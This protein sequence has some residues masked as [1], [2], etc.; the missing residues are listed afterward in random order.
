M[1]NRIITI[2]R[3]FGSGG[4]TIGRKV[5]EKLGIP[6]YDSELIARVAEESGYDKV[7]VEEMGEHT[8]GGW[9]LTVILSREFGSSAQDT[10]WFIQQK[11][12]AEIAAQESC[13]IVGRCA[14]YIL[15]EKAECLR[16]FIH[17]DR[18]KRA[19]RIVKEYGEQELPPLKRLEDK[20]R[21]RATY[22]RFYTH[23]EWGKAQNYHITLDSGELGIGR[24]VELIAGLY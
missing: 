2:S 20:D 13:V 18:E 6:C 10:L 8:K 4:R 5:A 19:E 17:A 11:V 23:M 3:E 12:I 21:R 22:Y 1:G 9:F 15:R 16:V 24:C 7:Y 14:D